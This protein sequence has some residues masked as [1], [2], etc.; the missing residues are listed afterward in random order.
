M[1][2][3]ILEKIKIEYFYCDD[4]DFDEYA[5]GEY[6]YADEPAVY[7]D[8]FKKGQ[9]EPFHDPLYGYDNDG[10][11]NGWMDDWNVWDDTSEIKWVDRPEE[12]IRI[13]HKFIEDLET[14][15]DFWKD[16]TEPGLAATI[17][18]AYF[19]GWKVRKQYR[20]NPHNSLGKYVIGKMFELS[21]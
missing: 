6:V 5:I 12:S 8:V 21:I 17:I 3:F 2:N 18:Q 9:N 20:Y 15:A 4:Y 19:R 13:I 11:M 1:I 10:W 14:K 16:T 7:Y